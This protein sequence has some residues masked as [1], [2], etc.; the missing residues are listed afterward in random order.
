MKC[1][2]PRDPKRRPRVP[3]VCTL[4][5][6]LKKE[7]FYFKSATTVPPDFRRLYYL[8][9][10]EKGVIAAPTQ[11]TK[12]IVQY[13]VS[14]LINGGKFYGV[15]VMS[16]LQGRLQ[17]IC[18]DF[19]YASSDTRSES[20]EIHSLDERNL[21]HLQNATH[22]LSVLFGMCSQRIC[23]P[24]KQDET[25]LLDPR[26][27]DSTLEQK[28]FVDSGPIFILSTSCSGGAHLISPN[29]CMSFGDMALVVKAAHTSLS[30]YRSRLNG[31]VPYDSQ[32]YGAGR[33]GSLRGTGAQKEEDGAFY[34]PRYRWTLCSG[35]WVP[36]LSGGRSTSTSL[37]DYLYTC[38]LL[39]PEE[40]GLL[41]I[42]LCVTKSQTSSLDITHMGSHK[43]RRRLACK[44]LGPTPTTPCE[45]LP[46]I[47]PLPGSIWDE[48]KDVLM[49][50]GR[51]IG[52]LYKNLTPSDFVLKSSNIPHQQHMSLV[53]GPRCRRLCPSLTSSRPGSAHKSNGG[54]FKIT[55]EHVRGTDVYLLEHVC[56]DEVC[57]RER[58][59]TLAADAFRRDISPELYN[60]CKAVL[61]G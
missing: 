47:K 23:D 24:T 35:T 57:R 1:D 6:R 11:F 30:R 18:F 13:V 56:H 53:P 43:K 15:E 29:V 48:L 52:Q 16:Q 33:G 17:K 46:L 25:T 9:A 5:E 58:T 49:T 26:S 40:T 39:S 21:L 14:H 54:F 50:Y 34:T 59:S 44:S 4:L 12:R 8:V 45:R 36:I 22:L 61:Y 28:R 20:N 19:D 60:A 55:S 37:A 2:T 27:I 3:P 42:S 31:T 38:L 51:D 41:P 32:I 7:G 10:G